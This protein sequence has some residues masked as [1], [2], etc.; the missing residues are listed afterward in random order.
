MFQMLVLSQRLMEIAHTERE[1]LRQLYR[2]VIS[3]KLGSVRIHVSV[4]TPST[5]EAFTLPVTL[6]TSP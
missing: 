6:V 5:S 3:P 1:V 2:S 4:L